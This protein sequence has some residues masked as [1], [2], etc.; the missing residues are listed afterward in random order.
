LSIKREIEPFKI[1]DPKTGLPKA[2]EDLNIVISSAAGG[3]GLAT[4]QYLSKLGYKNIFGIA[5]S[6]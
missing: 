6:Q 1:M 3:I 4:A 2:K 5:S